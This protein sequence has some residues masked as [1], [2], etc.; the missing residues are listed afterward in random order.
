MLTVCMPIDNRESRNNI[1]TRQHWK[2]KDFY[3]KKELEKE[4][5]S[6]MLWY[7]RQ[8]IQWFKVFGIMRE[9][10]QIHAD[11]RFVYQ[12]CPR[13]KTTRRRERKIRENVYFVVPFHS[14]LFVLLYST[15]IHEK[16]EEKL[17]KIDPM[18]LSFLGDLSLSL[19]S[20]ISTTITAV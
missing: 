14:F 2:N 17:L 11:K 19:L 20:R 8:T 10:L 7:H 9:I 18:F 4:V 3:E 1:F 5:Y 16:T 13:P 6:V 15:M 12:L